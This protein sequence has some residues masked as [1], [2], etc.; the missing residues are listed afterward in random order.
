MPEGDKSIYL[1]F[2]NGPHPNVTPAVLDIL[3]TYSIKATF[4]CVG[5]NVVKYPETFSSVVNDGHSIGNHTFNHLKGWK[6]PFN[7]YIENIK[8]CDAY[9]KSTLF[10]PPYGKISLKQFLLLRKEYRIIL[11][12]VMSYDFKQGISGQ[13][14]LS[15][16][17]KHT[18]NGSII[19]FH[20]SVKTMER[21]LYALPR[22]IEHYLALGYNFKAIP[23]L[24]YP[25]R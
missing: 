8:K 13:Q 24:R 17:L 16:V 11:W 5:D 22:V 12:S 3:K 21:M 20:D 9:F 2:D 23:D 14:C 7:A 15:N 18:S 6:T 1:T 10:R 19:V 25:T 4:F